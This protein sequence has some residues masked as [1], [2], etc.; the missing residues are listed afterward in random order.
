MAFLVSFLFHLRLRP[1]EVFKVRVRDVDGPT[2]GSR[3]D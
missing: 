1:G 2:A 3:Y